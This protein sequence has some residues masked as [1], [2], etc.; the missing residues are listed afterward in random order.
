MAQIGGRIAA[1]LVI[2]GYEGMQLHPRDTGGALLEINSTVGGENIDTAYWPAGPHWQ[3]FVRTER[4]LGIVGAE[5]QGAEPAAMAARWGQI[6][7]RPVNAPATSNASP[8][9]EST[10]PA[11]VPVDNATL[12]F[13]QATDG[14]GDGLGGIDL[15][16]ADVGAVIAAAKARGCAVDESGAAPIV[17]IGGVRFSLRT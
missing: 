10:V 8:T 2:G 9:G 16:V 15:R 5:L 4:V 11:T 17:V 1:P 12:R 14:R 7:Q 3:D 6:L 13:V